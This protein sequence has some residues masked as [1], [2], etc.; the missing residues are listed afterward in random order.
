[1][2]RSVGK[3]KWRSA[4]EMF[5]PEAATQSPVVGAL[6][7][8]LPVQSVQYLGS[9]YEVTVPYQDVTWTLLSG[10]KTKP[11]E[12]LSIYIDPHQVISFEKREVK[13]A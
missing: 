9:T 1:M 7:Y 10:Q 6:H 4:S 11:G 2:A 3:S 13:T 5:R 8:E 12:T